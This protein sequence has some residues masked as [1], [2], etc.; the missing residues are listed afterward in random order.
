LA[1]GKRQGIVDGD[2]QEGCFGAG[3][4]GCGWLLV[5][6]GGNDAGALWWRRTRGSRH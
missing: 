3:C 5:F 4:G 6:G 1:I 2:W